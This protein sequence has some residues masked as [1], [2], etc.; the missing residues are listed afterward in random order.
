MQIPESRHQMLT[1]ARQEGSFWCFRILTRWVQEMD[2]LTN[3]STTSYAGWYDPNEVRSPADRD[4]RQALPSHHHYGFFDEGYFNYFGSRKSNPTR[5]HAPTRSEP[6]S[7]STTWSIEITQA[8]RYAAYQK[9][10]D[11]MMSN[12]YAIRLLVD[13]FFKLI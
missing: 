11:H 1:V 3:S 4:L 9:M 6:S 2:S 5:V 12:E 10:S 7:S 13:W 8:L